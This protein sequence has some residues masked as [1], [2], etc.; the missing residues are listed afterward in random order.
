M[1][2]RE[3]IIEAD[4][5][6]RTSAGE[7]PGFRR[8]QAGEAQWRFLWLVGLEGTPHELFVELDRDPYLFK[9]EI[10]RGAQRPTKMDRYNLLDPETGEGTG[11][12]LYFANLRRV[13]PIWSLMFVNMD[14]WPGSMRTD[15]DEFPEEG[16]NW[17]PKYHY[18]KN[19]TYGAMQVGLQT[20]LQFG[21]RL[22]YRIRE[23]RFP[24][25]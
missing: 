13:A 8:L 10:L 15:I 25:P 23:R 11:K 16:D 22:F 21:Q 14:L 19:W 20:S 6:E 7:L 12:F 3:I 2:S 24:I 9:D 18:E 4:T 1:A 5:I 17:R